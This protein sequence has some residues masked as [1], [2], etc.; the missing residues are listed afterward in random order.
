MIHDIYIGH[1]EGYNDFDGI[2]NDKKN[3]DYITF[4]KETEDNELI[5]IMDIDTKYIHGINFIIKD[6]IKYEDN[7]YN[8]VDQTVTYYFGILTM[9][10]VV[11]ESEK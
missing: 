2:I 6:Q 5:V 9:Y 10:F 3:K 7:I 8:V 4:K 1:H 11:K